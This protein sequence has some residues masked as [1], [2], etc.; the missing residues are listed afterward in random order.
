M[1]LAFI[2]SGDLLQAKSSLRMATSMDPNYIDAILKLAEVDIKT[3]VVDSA[4]E[5]L[6][7]IVATEPKTNPT[8]HVVGLGLSAQR[9]ARESD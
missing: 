2:Q 8:L 3:G 6:G 7:K 1:A 9:N 5:A 4:I